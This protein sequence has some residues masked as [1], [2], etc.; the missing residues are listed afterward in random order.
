MTINLSLQFLLSL[1]KKIKKKNKYYIV[2]VVI[3]LLL[4][5]EISFNQLK[6][7]VRNYLFNIP[8]LILVNSFNKGMVFKPDTNSIKTNPR[9]I[10]HAGGGYKGFTYT[11]SLHALDFNYSSGFRYFELDINWT[12]DDSLVFIHDWD[13]TLNKYFLLNHSM[14]YHKY[15]TTKMAFGLHQLTLSELANWL[16]LHDSAY[17]IT[18]VKVKNIE[19]LRLIS[20]KYPT[21][22]NKVIPQIYFFREYSSVYKLGYNNIILTLYRSNYND[23]LV[24]EFVK[25]FPLFGITMW[26]S[27]GLTDLPLKLSQ[28]NVRVFAHTVNDTSL[29]SK[30]LLNGVYGVYT[31]FLNPEIN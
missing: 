17:I 11:N 5:N 13:E 1:L 20:E 30:L 28:N 24:V 12:T 3:C 23:E 22:I 4:L 21:I 19:A 29:R 31:D 26:Y 8:E 18:D 2:A 10:A 14:D 7:T 16:T 25:N 15:S 27:R 6:R 9:F